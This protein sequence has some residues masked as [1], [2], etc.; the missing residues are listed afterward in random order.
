MKN[1]ISYRVVVMAA[2][3]CGLLLGGTLAL[4]GCDQQTSTSK[5][6]SSKVVDTPEGKKKVTE[7]TET[8]TTT[9]KK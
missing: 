5:S 8:S 2:S 6:S 3:A 1:T 7:S 9:E 4:S